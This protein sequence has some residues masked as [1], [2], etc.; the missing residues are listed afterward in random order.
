MAAKAAIHDNRQRVRILAAWLDPGL[1]RD[2]D[3][4]LFRRRFLRRETPLRQH[5]PLSISVMTAM[6]P[7]AAVRM[8]MRDTPA[9][10]AARAAQAAV[11][12]EKFRIPRTDRGA[13]TGIGS[14]VFEFSGGR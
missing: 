5:K 1:R 13:G 4:E 6:I 14:R 2:D 10:R 11:T 7:V 9:K 3:L 12:F 8:T